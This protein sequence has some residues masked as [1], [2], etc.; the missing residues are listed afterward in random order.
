[1]FL[2]TFFHLGSSKQDRQL[3]RVRK[4]RI[5]GGGSRA[6]YDSDHFARVKASPIVDPASDDADLRAPVARSADE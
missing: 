6:V 1:M 3:N 5:L 2:Q 4:A